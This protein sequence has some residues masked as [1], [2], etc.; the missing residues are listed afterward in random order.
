MH[1]QPD[2]LFR[3]FHFLLTFL[4]ELKCSADWDASEKNANDSESDCRSSLGTYLTQL[5]ESRHGK[6]IQEIQWKGPLSP[7]KRIQVNGFPGTILISAS[8]HTSYKYLLAL[9]SGTPCLHYNWIRHS[10]KEGELMPIEPY[11]LP[12][13]IAIDGELLFYKQPSDSYLLESLRIEVFGETAEFKCIWTMILKEAGAKVVERLFSSSACRLDCI[14][15]DERPTEIVVERANKLHI[16][17]VRTVWIVECLK[18]QRLI[19]FEE[20]PEQFLFNAL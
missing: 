5:I 14:L 8:H 9:A 17:L 4:S 7:I 18:C 6:V 20:Y 1:T 10:V 2:Y 3:G 16:P 15:T 11:L 19:S 12:S 13:G